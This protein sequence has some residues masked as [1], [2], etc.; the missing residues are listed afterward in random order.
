MHVSF[1]ELGKGERSFF[2]VLYLCAAFTAAD[3]VLN[4]GWSA[5]NHLAWVAF[6]VMAARVAASSNYRW[7]RE[8]RAHHEDL[9]RLHQRVSHGCRETK[10]RP[11]R[12][13]PP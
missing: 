10:Q 9:V 4:Q 13:K 6:A 11:P 7:R 12:D 1:R 2:V 8:Q 3:V 5:V